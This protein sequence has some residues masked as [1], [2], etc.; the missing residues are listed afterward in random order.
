MSLSRVLAIDM[1]ARHVGIARS[2]LMRTITSPVVTLDRKKGDL[3]KQVL[4]LCDEE[5]GEIVIGLPL[6]MDGR[7]GDGA[8]DAREFA[9]RLQAAGKTVVLWD[10]RLTT[11]A[12]HRHMTEM[13][14]QTKK[15]KGMVDQLAAEM[16]L[17]GYLASLRG[18]TGP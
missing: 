5:V 9:A 17:S 11:T 7:E 8:K 1:G 18:T 14:T 13:G 2:D 4:D 15:K 12:A 16:I 3:L 6:H 10:E